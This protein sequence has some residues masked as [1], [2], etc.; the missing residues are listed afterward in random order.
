MS[1]YSFPLQSAPAQ[2]P[3]PYA[4][5]GAAPIMM[6]PTPT[7]FGG[8]TYQGVPVYTQ[9]APAQPPQP[10]PQLTEEDI[11]QVGNLS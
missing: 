2:V 10:P 6:L 7:G 9:A 11:K 8:R 3:V 4:V 1:T 5:P